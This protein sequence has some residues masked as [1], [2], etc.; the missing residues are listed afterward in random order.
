MAAGMVAGVGIT[1]TCKDEVYWT[2]ASCFVRPHI[3]Y[4]M[5]KNQN[6][7]TEHALDT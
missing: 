1:M 3:R 5:L 7:T 4:R 6:Y 2:I